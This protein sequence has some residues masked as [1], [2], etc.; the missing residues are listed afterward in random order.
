[1]DRAEVVF[2]PDPKD[3]PEILRRGD[4]ILGQPFLFLPDRPDEYKVLAVISGEKIRRQAVEMV[5]NDTVTMN[6]VYA[7]TGHKSEDHDPPGKPNGPGA[8]AG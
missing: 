5:F 6:F 7:L 2:R 4:L 1:M 8:G 3:V